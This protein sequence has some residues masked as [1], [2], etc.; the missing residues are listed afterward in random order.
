M[1]GSSAARVLVFAEL[2]PGQASLDK[3]GK[4]F[5]VVTLNAKSRDEYKQQ[6][7][8]GLFDGCE[9][10]LY[11]VSSRGQIGALCAAGALRWLMP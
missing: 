5:E 2:G 10:L 4:R 7:S 6:A 8:D 3:L 1:G 9:A 11:R